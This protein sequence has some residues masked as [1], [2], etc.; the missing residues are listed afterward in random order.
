MV[1]TGFSEDLRL[2]LIGHSL[3]GLNGQFNLN[4]FLKRLLAV[5]IDVIGVFIHNFIISSLFTLGV[6]FA[7]Y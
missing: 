6:Y 2:S 3:R 7:R 1:I 5:C 4:G